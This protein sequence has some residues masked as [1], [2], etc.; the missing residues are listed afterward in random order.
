MKKK[1]HHK[2]KIKIFF[3]FQKIIF[4]IIF[5]RKIRKITKIRDF[6]ENTKFGVFLS[7]LTPPQFLTNPTSDTPTLTNSGVW[8]HN[9]CA[10]LEFLGGGVFWGGGQL[11]RGNALG[12]IYWQ[13]HLGGKN[14][15]KIEKWGGVRNMT[16]LTNC[17]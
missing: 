15:P 13:I 17:Y 8:W 14:R 5:L 9:L 7:I 12:N 1:F 6:R 3:L 10:D 11:I 16:N 4:E 2:K